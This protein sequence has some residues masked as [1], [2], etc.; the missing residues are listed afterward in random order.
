MARF[1]KNSIVQLGGFDS[2]VIAEELL[3]GQDTYWNVTITDGTT[4]NL[5]LDLTDWTFEFRLICRQVT[6]I[7]DTRQGLELVDLRPVAGAPVL[8]LDSN[9]KVY[10]PVN[11]AVRLI[12][13]D[14]VFSQFSPSI[15]TDAPPVYTGYLGAVL[16]AVGTLGD[17]GYIPPQMKK[18]LLCFVIRSDG[19]SSQTA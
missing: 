19:I 14:S 17:V 6:S 9:V 15:N 2:D 7:E 8:I 1:S 11:G 4:D 12:I 3:Y 5:P 18:I 16:P 10:N 13:D